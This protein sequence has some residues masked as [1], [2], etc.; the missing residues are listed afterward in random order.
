M[1]TASWKSKLHQ[2]FNRD[3]NQRRQNNGPSE[4]KNFKVQQEK[5][6]AFDTR[7]RGIQSVPLDRIVGTVGRYHDFDN[8]FRTIR[9]KS[10]IVGA[11]TDIWVASDFT[12]HQ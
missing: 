3:G 2:I 4:V 10:N 1:G 7:D 12:T 8:R 11:T 6:A 9:P 5:E